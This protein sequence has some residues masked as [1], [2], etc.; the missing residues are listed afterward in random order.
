MSTRS[1]NRDGIISRAIILIACA[2]LVACADTRES[3]SERSPSSQST[4]SG[5]SGT[6][7][8]PATQPTTSPA[9]EPTRSTAAAPA[10]SSTTPSGS[11][12]DEMEPPSRGEITVQF[13][14]MPGDYEDTEPGVLVG[15]TTPGAS[16]EAAGILEGDRLVTWN[17]KPIKDIRNWMGYLAQ[18]KPG[19]IVDVGVKR[20]GKIIPI[21]V[22]LKARQD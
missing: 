15:S 20:E 9:S 1:S 5:A 17:G 8:T 19:D 10:A 21:K 6:D 18:S 4:N 2:G 7:H 22:P 12:D 3:N 11:V 14:I 16:A 13:G